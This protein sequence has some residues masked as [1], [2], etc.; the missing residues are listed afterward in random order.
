MLFLIILVVKLSLFYVPYHFG[1]LAYAD[2][3]ALQ[4][5]ETPQTIHHYRLFLDSSFNH[6]VS[7]DAPK[8][9]VAGNSYTISNQLVW[10]E[11]P[12]TG[13][14]FQ[15]GTSPD[16]G[17]IHSSVVFDE[18]NKIVESEINVLSDIEG[19]DMIPV[20]YYGTVIDN[21]TQLISEFSTI[22]TTYIV[23][24]GLKTKLQ[25]TRVVNFVIALISL[26]IVVWIFLVIW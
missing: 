18:N 3:M 20:V 6:F 22:G 5:F 4:S 15:L 2:H 24:A 19:K 26:V 25:V 23:P 10:G 14:E 16:I 7:I 1:Q 21:N 8:Y 17:E 13:L 11:I 9:L 12:D